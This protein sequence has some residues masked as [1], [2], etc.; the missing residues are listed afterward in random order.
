[1]SGPNIRRLYYSAGEIAE[2]AKI[3]PHILTGWE[4]QFPFLKPMVRGGKRLYTPADMEMVFSIKRCKDEGK[5]N[6]SIRELLSGRKNKET[7]ETDA[8]RT[9]A[10]EPAG[11][12]TPQ[13]IMGREL[14]SE[15]LS[16]L[17]AILQIL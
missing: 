4:D 9:D 6:D 10:F 12:E 14:V 16:E 15:I 7:G 5:T 17:R 3:K 1:M 8:F 2:A 11:A 13:R